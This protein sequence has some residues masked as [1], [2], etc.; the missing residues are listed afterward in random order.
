VISL[1]TTTTIGK[2]ETRETSQS[3]LV[4]D[5]EKI[6]NQ[7]STDTSEQFNS[8]LVIG[9]ILTGIVVIFVLGIL[10][11]RYNLYKKNHANKK[12]S[13]LSWDNMIHSSSKSCSVVSDPTS[14]HLSRNLIL[15]LLNE[16]VIIDEIQSKDAQ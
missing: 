3:T 11:Y 8:I 15:N 7:I 1:P 6:K 4:Y 12:M 14:T 10:F 2:S 9:L 16:N 13:T 5:S